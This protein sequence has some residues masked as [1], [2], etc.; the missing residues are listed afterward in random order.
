MARPAG[1]GRA[2]AARRSRRS[3]S[4]RMSEPL[5]WERPLGSRV[6][7]AEH[8]EFRVWA[9]SRKHE[10]NSGSAGESAS[11]AAR[12]AG[13]GVHEAV[14]PARAGDDYW[15]VL[16]GRRLPD[17]CSRWQPDGLRGPSRVLRRLPTPRPF[18][19][20]RPE[21]A[22]HLR[23][24]R[25]HLQRRGHVRR[26]R[27]RTWP[28]SRELGVTAIELMPVAE[29]P[30]ARGWGYDG[31][32][33]SAAQSSYGGPAG[34]QRLVEAAHAAGLAVILD[35][36]YNHV[37]ASGNKALEAFGP[38]FTDQVRDPLGQGDQL[39]R[40]RVRPGARMGLPERRGLGPRLRRRRP[41]PRR[42]PRDLRL[43]RRAHRRRGRA[44]GA[45]ARPGRLRDRRVRAQ[46][47]V[48]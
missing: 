31:V 38:Y 8:T 30:G 17:P 39:R 5:P 13:H 29:F 33:L 23:A 4:C 18:E 48:A 10:S 2:D 35:V 37:G 40:R 26:P 44:A 41:A 14:A 15:F 36:V 11:L 7:D 27:S 34:L 1:L 42:D 6:V 25:R 22:D 46:R 3:G 47:P 12:D 16:D 43:E 9:P 20:P 45:R 24:A 28:G 19:R 32:Y 21:R